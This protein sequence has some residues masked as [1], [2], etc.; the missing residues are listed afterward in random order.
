M[1][2]ENNYNPSQ[3]FMLKDGV[4]DPND[5]KL[6]EL[7]LDEPEGYDPENADADLRVLPPDGEYRVVLTIS[8]NFP[9]EIRPPKDAGKKP[10]IT[11]AIQAKISDPSSKFDKVNLGLTFVNSFISAQTGQSSLGNI[12]RIIGRP[13][14]SGMTFAQ[15]IE[16]ANNAFKEEPVALART[17]WEAFSEDCRNAFETKEKGGKK[18]GVFLR[19]M[20]NFPQKPDGSH[21]PVVNCPFT[22]IEITANARVTRFLPVREGYAAAV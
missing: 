3:D 5:P 13:L 18:D 21:N 20:H 16:H 1:S 15:I 11:G 6:A 10:F 17:Q 8:D 22:D 9:L 12:L 7:T 14:R 4:I 2:E 19:G